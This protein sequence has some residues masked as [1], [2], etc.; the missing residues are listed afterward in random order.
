MGGSAQ[1]GRSHAP[2]E[3]GAVAACAAA[4][5]ARTPVST[6]AETDGEIVHMIQSK[7]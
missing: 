6:R 2:L 3:A 1:G 7:F 5:P 4:A